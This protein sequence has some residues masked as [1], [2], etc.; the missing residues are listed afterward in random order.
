VKKTWEEAR[1]YCSDQG[2]YLVSCESEAEWEYVHKW[3]KQT[4]PENAFDIDGKSWTWLG[5][6]GNGKNGGWKWVTGRE[7]STSDKNW[8]NRPG[9]PLQ[10]NADGLACLNT[11]LARASNMDWTD[12]DCN[13]Q[14]PFICEFTKGKQ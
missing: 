10:P 4:T 3:A 7:I 11:N 9:K 5:A 12:S 6:Q 2:Q 13:V 14:E 8:D 1:K